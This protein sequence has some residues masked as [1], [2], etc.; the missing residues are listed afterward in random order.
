MPVSP[1]S[2]LIQF[3][4]DR[5]GHDFRYAVDFGKIK[6]QLSWGPKTDFETGLKSTVQWYIEHQEFFSDNKK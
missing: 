4:S 6:S 2:S 5:P 1:C 3:V